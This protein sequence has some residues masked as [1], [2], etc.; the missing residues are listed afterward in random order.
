MVRLLFMAVLLAAA[1]TANLLAGKYK[2][3]F[4]YQLYRLE[5]DAHGLSNSRVAP[6]CA[7]A[8]VV[9]DMEAF[10]KE[11]CKPVH[12]KG[13][14]KGVKVP[15]FS[16][17]NW[18]SIG[19]GADIDIF[20]AEF[21]KT[22]FKGDVYDDKVFKGWGTGLSSFE[23]VMNEAENI[24][25]DALNKLKSEGRQ[26]ADDRD[27]KIKAAL[28]VHADA[29]R[30]DL[31]KAI[32]D[33]FKME[34]AGWNIEYTGPIERLP[35]PGYYKIDTHET[36]NSNQG[37]VGFSN[38]EQRVRNYVTKFNSAGQGKRHFEALS[39]TESVHKNIASA[40]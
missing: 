22:G 1:T 10:M 40:C 4:F 38:V 18:A 37:Q 14:P 17:V 11:I 32:T 30:C 31:A 5:V 12:P 3:L 21:D 19:E 36:I 33:A 15:D 13:A 34:F 24:G 39:K 23:K 16:K 8:G 25:I 20:S 26:P 28:K 9:C 2:A 27:S 6:N 7:K 29:R 35:V